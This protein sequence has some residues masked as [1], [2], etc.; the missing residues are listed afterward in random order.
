M[1]N[2]RIIAVIYIID[3]KVVLS[4][5]FSNYSFIGSIDIV[6][7][8][9][10][11]WEVDEIILL[12]IKNSIHKNDRLLKV[13][14]QISQLSQTPLSV[15][16][17]INNIRQISKIINSGVEKV[18]L[19]SNIYNNYSLIKI[20]SDEFGSQAINCCIDYKMDGSNYALY[21]HSGKVKQNI[22]VTEHV[23][24]IQDHG[25]GEMMFNS[26]DKD[27]TGKGYDLNFYKRFKKIIKLPFIYSGGFGN[28]NHIIESINKGIVS[29]GIG[30]SLNFIEHCPVVYRNGLKTKVNKTFI[31]RNSNISYK[32]FS[33]DKFS[34][35]GKLDDNLL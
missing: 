18:V 28:L 33:I 5:N 8:Y 17:G 25:A 31:R 3:N 11:R 7:S 20:A 30:N 27:G 9:M 24:Q 15:G 26:I 34:R 35:L 1:I 4:R 21:S 22:D 19:N 29:F 6:V 16:G 13:L 2:S 32:K 10:N 12:D 23:K 14:K